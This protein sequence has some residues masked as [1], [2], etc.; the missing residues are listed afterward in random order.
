VFLTPA[1]GEYT[2]KAPLV[3]AFAISPRPQAHKKPPQKTKEK[4]THFPLNLHL[5]FCALLTQS[6][7]VTGDKTNPVFARS[8][9][10]TGNITIK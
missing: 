5:M 7:P 2:A 3:G 4:I 9:A 10:K 1:P 6:N 8:T